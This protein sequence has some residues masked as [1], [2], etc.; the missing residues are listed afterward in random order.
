MPGAAEVLIQDLPA[1]PDDADDEA[2]YG[3]TVV[4]DRVR[5]HH[6]IFNI[7]FDRVA[8]IEKWTKSRVGF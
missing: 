2:A 5:V 1:W 3:T 8:Q 4:G 6:P 7:P